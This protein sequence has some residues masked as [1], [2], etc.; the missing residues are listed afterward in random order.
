MGLRVNMAATLEA[1]A[2]PRKGEIFPVNDSGLSIGRDP[3]NSVAILDSALS[4]H[5]CQIEIRG[6]TFALRDL[7]SSNGTLLNGAQLKEMV[8]R[9]G[10]EIRIGASTFAFRCKVEAVATSSSGRNAG[11]GTNDSTIILRKEDA[12]YLNPSAQMKAGQPG[13][14]AVRDLNALLRISQTVN[15]VHQIDELEK[16]IV[17]AIFEVSP[18]GRAAILWID[19]GDSDFVEVRGWDRQRG[20]LES[21]RPSRTVVNLVIKD[22]H[23]IVCNDVMESGELATES[24]LC[25]QVRSVLAVPIE[26]YAKVRGILYL[27]GDD[28]KAKFDAGLL[29]LMAAIG[30]IA[31]IAFENARRVEWLEGENRRLKEESR[32]EHKMIGESRPMRAVYQFIEK[33]AEQDATVLVWGESGTG[34]ELVAR[35]IHENSPRKW[36]PCIAINCAAITETLLESELFG[37]EKGAFTGAQCQKKGKLELAEGGTIFLD[38]IGEL[39]PLLQAKLLRV[40]QEREVERVGGTKTIKID[41]RVIAATNRDLKEMVKQGK[42]R[43]DLYYRL[44]VVSIRM[45]ALRERPD[46]IQ[47]LASHFAKK[48]ALKTGHRIDGISPDAKRY[49]LQYN[50]PGNVRELENAMERAVVLSSGGIL[51]PEDFPES[52]LETATPREIPTASTFYGELLGTKRRAVLRALD[53]SHGNV[54]EAAKSLG[55]H[56]NYLHRLMNNLGI[57]KRRKAMTASAS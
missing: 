54:T 44:N 25:T 52:I 31:G 30:S 46:D 47:L 5:H 26:F 53:E 3:S 39:A 17:E 14:R 49:L 4:R 12:V 56:P 16:Q 51:Y 29:E 50:W 11:S 2:G 48:F 34:K 43:E 57:E 18:A 32:I 41:I 22:G 42:F 38:E 24:L 19:A 37:H 23:A 1:I 10:D 27:E 33:V 13:N 21:M 8:L 20:P 36:K 15:R 28:P 40:L 7:D 45:P 55:V 6:N 35:A 9:E